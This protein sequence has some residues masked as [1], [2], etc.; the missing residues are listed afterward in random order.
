V[1][2]HA[3]HV[4]QRLRQQRHDEDSI[5]AVALRFVGPDRK[6]VRAQQHRRQVGRVAR[7]AQR[8]NQ[9]RPGAVR[10]PIFGDDRVGEEP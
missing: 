6:C 3:K 7:S 10:Q 8:P 1:D 2:D 5:A 4:E 9:L